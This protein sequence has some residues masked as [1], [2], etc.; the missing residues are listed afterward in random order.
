V[1]NNGDSSVSG[2]GA[3]EKAWQ[4]LIEALASGQMPVLDLY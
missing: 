3:G 4:D 1:N 2:E